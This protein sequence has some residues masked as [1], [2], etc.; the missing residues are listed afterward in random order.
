VAEPP[1]AKSATLKP[2]EGGF[3]GQNGGGM[4]PKVMAQ[5][6][7]QFFIFLFLKKVSKYK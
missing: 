7:L 4:R 6:P 5:P 3:L 2:N 1:Q